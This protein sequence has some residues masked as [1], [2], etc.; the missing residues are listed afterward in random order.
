MQKITVDDAGSNSRIDKYIMRLLPGMP[1]GLMYKQ[2]RKKNITLNGHKADGSEIV[3]TGD[4]LCFFLADETFDKFKNA[5]NGTSVSGDLQHYIDIYKAHAEDVRIVCENEHLLIMDK[6]SGLLSQK[7][8][9]ED[10]S[11]N[12]WML[13]YLASTGVVTKESITHFKPSVLNRL[14]RNTSGLVLGSKTYKCANILSRALKERTLHKYY[15]TRVWGRFDADEGIYEAILQKDASTN[16]VNILT[17]S[18]N[19]TNAEDGD[20]IRTGVRLIDTF[21]SGYKTAEG[22][23]LF[24]SDLEIE[25]ITGKSHQIRAH[26]A[27]M[28]YPIIGDPKY[29]NSA[30]DRLMYGSKPHVQMLYAYKVVF[31]DEICRELGLDN[32]TVMSII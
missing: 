4:E 2:F 31:G 12:E 1:K 28:G 6:P 32:N 5:E 29:G 23:I 16:T 15:K 30:Y 8:K 13:G 17:G 22:A 27:S 20:I 3:K 18:V 21:D 24:Q 14:D 9:P 26:L 10:I 25:L 7:S 11:L 19:I